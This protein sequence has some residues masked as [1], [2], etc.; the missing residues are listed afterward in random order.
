M[1]ERSEGTPGR[2]SVTGNVG[3]GY[4]QGEIDR[5]RNRIDELD[6]Q[7]VALLAERTAAVRILTEHK[8]DEAAVRS[9]D[10][11]RAVLARVEMLAERHGM[12][13]RIAR[14][15]YRALIEELTAMQ[16]VRLARRRGT[17]V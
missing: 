3:P 8:T 14:E 15:T 16:L 12:P 9:P 5:M 17:P 2:H 10:R 7:I 1:T 4:A 11:V 13:P 6:E